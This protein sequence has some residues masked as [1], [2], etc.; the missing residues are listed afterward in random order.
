MAAEKCAQRKGVPAARSAAGATR[1]KNSEKYRKIL[2]NIDI[3]HLST[4]TILHK[5][6][7]KDF[8]VV[9]CKDQTCSKKLNNF[10]EIENYL[11]NINN[12]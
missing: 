11:K 5:A 8:F 12:V 7:S 1:K 2:Q 4:S 10:E 9:I 3:N 6:N